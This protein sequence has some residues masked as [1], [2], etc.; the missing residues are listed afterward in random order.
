VDLAYGLPEVLRLVVLFVEHWVLL[1]ETLVSVVQCLVL[2][3]LQIASDAIF[4]LT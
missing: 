4:Q 2:W 3:Q 1:V